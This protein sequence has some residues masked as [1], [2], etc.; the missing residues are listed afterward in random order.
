MLAID[1]PNVDAVQKLSS[2]VTVILSCPTPPRPLASPL[3]R[4]VFELEQVGR[5]AGA[6]A[7]AQALRDDAFEAH[8]AGVAKHDL[9]RVDGLYA[10]VIR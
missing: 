9:A 3:V 7:R 6:I 8:L 5:A 10:G 1:G 2:V 4:R